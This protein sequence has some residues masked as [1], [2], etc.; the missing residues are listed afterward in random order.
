MPIII[1]HSKDRITE[2]ICQKPAD[3]NY[4]NYQG[5]HGDQDNLSHEYYG[6]D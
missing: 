5:L 3:C 4:N 6:D 1:S 2:L